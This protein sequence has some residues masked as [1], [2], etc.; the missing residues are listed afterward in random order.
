M[1]EVG[2]LAEARRAWSR[3]PKAIRIYEVQPLLD[4]CVRRGAFAAAIELLSELP[5]RTMSD[6]CNVSIAAIVTAARARWPGFGG[7]LH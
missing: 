7:Y 6:R 2:A 4:A 1:V 5:H 3:L